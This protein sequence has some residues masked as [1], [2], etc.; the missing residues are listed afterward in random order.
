MYF[1]IYTIDQVPLYTSLFT[2]ID[3]ALFFF[4]KKIK[5]TENR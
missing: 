4:I 3:I 5:N 2:F 1:F